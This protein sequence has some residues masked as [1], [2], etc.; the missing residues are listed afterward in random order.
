MVKDFSLLISGQKVEFGKMEQTKNGV[1]FV[2]QY[3][4][5]VVFSPNQ[6]QVPIFYKNPDF[7]EGGMWKFFESLSTQISHF[8]I[9]R[10]NTLKALIANID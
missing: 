4:S 6:P 9:Q 3:P 8:E 2:S 7:S 10:L 5:L 1:D